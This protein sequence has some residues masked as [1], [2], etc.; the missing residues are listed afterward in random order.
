MLEPLSGRDLVT[1]SRKIKT[2]SNSSERERRYRQRGDRIT[3]R[4]TKVSIATGSEK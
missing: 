4:R 1:R 2:A 3:S